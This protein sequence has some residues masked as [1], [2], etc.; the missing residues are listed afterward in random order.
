[1][2]VSGIQE[3]QFSKSLVNSGKLEVQPKLTFKNTIIPHFSELGKR[4]KY[5]L[6]PKHKNASLESKEN[7]LRT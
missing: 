6:R 2:K 3:Y 5:S 7:Y 4:L 1:M